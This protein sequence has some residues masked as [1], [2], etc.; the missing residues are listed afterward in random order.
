MTFAAN[1]RKTCILSR[2]SII[3]YRVRE[4]TKLG[5]SPRVP[6]K[7]HTVPPEWARPHAGL[8]GCGEYKL[9]LSLRDSW[10]RHSTPLCPSPPPI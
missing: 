8:R 4:N 3:L 5:H 10:P 7:V 1:L 2:K 6:H 9:V